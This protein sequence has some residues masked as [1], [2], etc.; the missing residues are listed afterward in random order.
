MEVRS[1]KKLTRPAGGAVV[2]L[3][4]ALISAA[5]TAAASLPT[6]TVSYPSGFQWDAGQACSFPIAGVPT[7]GFE[8]TTV[9][10]DVYEMRSVRIKG[11]Y[12]NLVTHKTYWV[13]DTWTELDEWDATTQLYTI[14][15]NGQIDVPFWP[16]DASPF[17]GLVTEAAYYRFAGTTV[18][19]VDFNGTPR[20]AAFAWSGHITD[21][22]AALS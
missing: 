14:T 13:N 10:S 7:S 4:V 22:C 11:Y 2:A 8:A 19:V 6:R 17:G 18:N 16:G 3:A 12:E 21:I 1:V 9:F 5:P 15:G 20:T